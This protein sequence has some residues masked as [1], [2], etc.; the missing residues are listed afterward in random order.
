MPAD[1]P[2]DNDTNA[3]AFS[4]LKPTDSRAKV[5][6]DEILGCKNSDGIVQVL[7]LSRL[8][9]YTGLTYYQVHLDP[10]RPRIAPEVSAN[11][12]SLFY[13]YGRGHE[14]QQSLKY[15][16]NAMALEEYQGSRYYYTPE[17]LLY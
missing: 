17:C 11:I 5:L 14:V 10:N 7:R 2:E 6:I 1:Y 4:I 13:S 15:L 8:S 12:L 3:V 9:R 16:K